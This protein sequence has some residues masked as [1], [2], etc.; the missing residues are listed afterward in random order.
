MCLHG[1]NGCF[2]MVISLELENMFFHGKNVVWMGELGAQ[3]NKRTGGWLGHAAP[4]MCHVLF[5]E[6]QEGLV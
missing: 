1:D 3:L 2:I 5:L 4:S 6:L